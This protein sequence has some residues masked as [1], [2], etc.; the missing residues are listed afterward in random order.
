MAL[1]NKFSLYMLE[2]H[3]SMFMD[4]ADNSS[5]GSGHDEIMRIPNIIEPDDINYRDLGFMLKRE[6][7]ALMSKRLSEGNTYKHVTL[8]HLGWNWTTKTKELTKLYQF[9]DK[10]ASQ[11]PSAFDQ[12]YN[13]PY[14]NSTLSGGYS[15]KLAQKPGRIYVTDTLIN[16]LIKNR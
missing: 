11:H 3:N 13:Y 16:G 2:K 10:Y 7:D 15:D 5:G 8:S 4:R 1:I 6:K 9:L 12:A 14:P